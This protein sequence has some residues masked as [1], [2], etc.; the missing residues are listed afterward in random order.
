VF[1]PA[2][3]EGLHASKTCVVFLGPNGLGPW[4][5]EE[6]QAAID[7]RVS[8]EAFRVIP[9]LLPGAERPRRG[10]VAHLEFLLNASWVE[11]PKTLNDERAFQSLVWGITGN[12]P[13]KLDEPYEERVCPYRGLEAFRPE[14]ARFFFGR[15]SLTGWLVSALRREVRAAQGVRFLAVLG[16]SGSG[17]SSLVLAG[18]VIII[19]QFE[20]VFTFRPQGEQALARFEQDR[21]RFFANLL[22]VSATPGGRVA[23]VLTMRSDFLSACAAFPRLVAVLSAH[24]ELVGPMT[25][26]ELRDAIKQPAFRVGCEVQPELTERLLAE[27]RGSRGCCRCCSSP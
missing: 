3:A 2:L 15:D 9:V 4:Q 18:L 11:F 5:K 17:K 19:D 13:K 23:V 26:D 1:Q 27:W 22:H 12:K 10:D 21:D 16:P 7:R 24:Q 25:V 6:L 20:E 14:D 8:K